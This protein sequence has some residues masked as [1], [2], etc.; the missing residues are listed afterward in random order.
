MKKSNLTSVVAMIL[1]AGI[2]FAACSNTAEETVVDT[3]A[4]VTTEMTMPEEVSN[5]IADKTPLNEESISTRFVSEENQEYVDAYV[6]SLTEHG[7]SQFYTLLV[8]CDDLTSNPDCAEIISW[9]TDF[10]C[11]E[12]AIFEQQPGPVLYEDGS[13]VTKIDTIGYYSN[14]IYNNLP[15]GE[16][17]LADFWASFANYTNDDA[18]PVSNRVVLQDN[19]LVVYEANPGMCLVHDAIE[20]LYS[21]GSASSH[22]FTLGVP[23]SD[24]EDW[25]AWETGSI[26]PAYAVPL[27]D[28]TT[29]IY[30]KLYFDSNNNLI[31]M[32]N[33]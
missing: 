22:D 19:L 20:I 12:D 29:G 14:F 9:Y 8:A 5:L 10:S 2:A 30:Y 4:E 6:D 31:G 28:N 13:T 16:I 18:L 24:I 7:I 17:T 1:V 33:Y 3:A 15:T 23:T 26:E 32:N 21:D 27:R 25:Y 11:D